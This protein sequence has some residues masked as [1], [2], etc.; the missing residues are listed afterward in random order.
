L[1]LC[2][3]ALVIF[4]RQLGLNHYTG[5]MSKQF[6]ENLRFS[7]VIGWHFSEWGEILVNISRYK[8]IGFFPGHIGDWLFILIGIMGIAGFIHICFIRKNSVSFIVKAYLSFYILLMFNWPF[9]DPRFWVPVIPL[10]AAVI[11]QTS[12]SQARVIKILDITCFVIYA[13]LGLVSLGY[14]TYTSFN[15][16]EL[17]KTQARGVYRNEYET[18][19]F[20]KPLSDTVTHIDPYLVEFLNKYDR[21]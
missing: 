20:G 19:F 11:S 21:K 1:L 5:V 2:A 15:K 12:F 13:T 9:A 6:K 3:A 4:S 18:H 14:F 8:V 7:D 16:R 10:I 17:S